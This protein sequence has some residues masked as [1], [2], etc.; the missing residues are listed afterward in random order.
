MRVSICLHDLH[1]NVGKPDGWMKRNALKPSQELACRMWIAL[2]TLK[3]V[4]QPN[5]HVKKPD[6]SVAQAYKNQS[7]QIERCDVVCTASDFAP[8]IIETLD[9]S[10]LL[11]FT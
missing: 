7:K 8:C 9:G 2:F 1:E 10:S 11:S 6:L 4:S 3:N 5:A